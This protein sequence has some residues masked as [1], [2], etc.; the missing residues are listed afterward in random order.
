MIILPASTKLEIFSHVLEFAKIR[1]V[2]VMYLLPYYCPT[3]CD[4]NVISCLLSSKT[5]Q[6]Y[7]AP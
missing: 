5:Q 3:E 1:P 4:I 7:F 6:L 2:G